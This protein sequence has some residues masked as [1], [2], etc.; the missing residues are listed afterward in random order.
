MKRAQYRFNGLP[1]VFLVATLDG[2]EVTLTGENTHG[3]AQQISMSVSWKW[4][5][6]LVCDI[7]DCWK[8]ELISRLGEISRT[9]RELGLEFP[10]RKDGQ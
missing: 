5:R 10:E 7:R 8:S 1:R 6:R 9:N 3:T 2:V 4:I